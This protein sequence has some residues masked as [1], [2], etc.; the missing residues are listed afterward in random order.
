LFL[1]INSLDA[2]VSYGF[3]DRLSLTLTLPFSHGT[4]SR[5]YADGNRHTVSATGLGDISLVS[6][7]WFR[8]PAC[9]PDSNFSVGLGVKTSS[10]NNSVVDDFFLADRS[11]IK[12][13]VDQSI[14]LGDGGVGAVL[15]AQ[16]FQRL[17]RR[18]TGYFYGWYMLTPRDQTAV[19]SPLAGVP[20][21]VP[22]VYSARP[23][24]DYALAPQ[25]GLSVSLGARIDGIP[26]RDLVGGSDG[27][28]TGI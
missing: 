20:L 22:D 6:D 10:G 4:H 11:V 7:F 12:N 27:F 3:T 26:K 2:S 8:N 1:N 18:T 24:L 9:H 25:Y 15:Q 5:Y 23:G 28:R 17:F 16:G 13:P 21:S 19:P 14:Q